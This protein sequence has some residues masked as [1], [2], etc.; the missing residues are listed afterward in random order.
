MIRDKKIIIFA[1]ARSGSNSLYEILCTNPTIKLMVEPFNPYALRDYYPLFYAKINKRLNIKDKKSLFNYMN[2]IYEKFDGMKT[3]FNH[4]PYELNKEILLNKNHMIIFLY[5]KNALQSALS[6]TI[7]EKMNIWYVSNCSIM[8]YRNKIS[9]TLIDNIDPMH[10]QSRITQIKS[11]VESYK[12]ILE[13]NNV[14]Y[15]NI[16]YEDLFSKTAESEKI[17]KI[18]EIFNFLGCSSELNLEKIRAILE[19]KNKKMSD[20]DVYLRI[21]NIFQIKEALESKENGFL[22]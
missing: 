15:F 5:R 14:K 19:P 2:L 20:E 22:F 21:P 8:D 12:K 13:I 4:L 1:H 16:A 10:L 6:W 18:K 7:A 3:L 9:C 11:E 17:E